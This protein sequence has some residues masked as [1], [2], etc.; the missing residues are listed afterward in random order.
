VIDMNLNSTIIDMNSKVRSGT[1]ADY[2]I[3]LSFDRRY[4]G[5]VDGLETATL[6]TSISFDVV[7]SKVSAERWDKAMFNILMAEIER[8]IT[9][10]DMLYHLEDRV[11]GQQESEEIIS[12]IEGLMGEIVDDLSST[13]RSEFDSETMG[14]Y[15][16]SLD[17]KYT[18][19]G[20]NTAE[21]N[22]GSGYEYI[23]DA[24]VRRETYSYGEGQAMY[25]TAA[26]IFIFTGRPVQIPALAG[27]PGGASITSLIYKYS[28]EDFF[29]QISYELLERYTSRDMLAGTVACIAGA[30]RGTDSIAWLNQNRQMRLST[31]NSQAPIELQEALYLV[32]SLYEFK[33]NTPVANIQV[34]NFTLTNNMTNLDNKY[35]MHVRAAFELEIYAEPNMNPTSPVK[36]R[37]I[38]S[39]LAEL[40]KRVKL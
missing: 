21:I 27:M 28:L 31:R 7:E 15:S 35:R 40:D 6:E 2:Y 30:P 18:I 34:R 25:P 4:T 19:I 12:Y 14:T 38:L 29:G 8:R 9:D 11:A 20:K 3:M 24:W 26:G 39:M 23:A 10:N 33:T 5:S 17:K 13:L 16:V 37:E 32:V 1:I 22:V 36:I